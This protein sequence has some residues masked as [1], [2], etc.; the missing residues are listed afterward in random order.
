MDDNP[1]FTGE[2]SDPENCFPTFYMFEVNDCLSLWIEDAE[3]FMHEINYESRFADE[4]NG[5]V[6]QQDFV[7]KI[8]S[9]ARHKVI[10]DYEII[11][12]IKT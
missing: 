4:L 11:S 9:I 10:V 5:L 12:R 8:I 3:N 7:Q 1:I 2:D 6:I